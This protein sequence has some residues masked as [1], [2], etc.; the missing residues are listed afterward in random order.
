MAPIL[1][2]R[3]GV[4][5]HIYNKEHV[6]PHIH[7]V[8]AEEEA[9]VNIRTGEIFVGDLPKNKL[10]I[11]QEWLNENNRREIVEENFYELNP[12]LRPKLKEKQSD[13]DKKVPV[14]KKKK[15]G[16]KK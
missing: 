8:Y 11:V 1:E 15:K 16:G 7:A 3:D 13:K 12:R 2:E 5:I 9:L 4:S 14:K 10:R 6:P